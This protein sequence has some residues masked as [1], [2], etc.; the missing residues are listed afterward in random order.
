M[1]GEAQEPRAHRQIPELPVSERGE[2]P[3]PRAAA[4]R[5]VRPRAGV[6][7][8]ELCRREDGGRIRGPSVNEKGLH[9]SS[10]G[11]LR[12]G[13]RQAGFDRVFIVLDVLSFFFDITRV[14]SFP[15]GTLDER[16][17]LRLPIGHEAF[18]GAYGDRG[19]S[20]CSAISSQ[21]GQH[22]IMASP[23]IEALSRSH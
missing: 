11:G 13:Y 4:L 21:S 20:G 7:G 8:G 15:G 22:S 16:Q 17:Q 23:N 6:D 18:W 1:E 12:C 3:R 9:P 19:K 5:Q 2:P 10:R 14:G